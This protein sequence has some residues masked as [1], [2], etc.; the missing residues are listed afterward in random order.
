MKYLALAFL[1]LPQQLLASH[2]EYRNGKVLVHMTYKECRKLVVQHKHTP[3]SDVAY[4][5]GKGS[6]GRPV[7]P[8]DVGGTPQFNFPK[9][10]IIPV[11]LDLVKKYGFK[12]PNGVDLAPEVS[13]LV[14][15][16][17]GRVTFN[18][19]ALE[20]KTYQRLKNICRQQYKL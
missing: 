20:D 14:I 7:M 12:V 13:E 17:D 2:M 8:A 10:I 19:T 1:F 6:K 3:R 11:E 15:H 18:G 4:Q 16:M 5:P 9:K